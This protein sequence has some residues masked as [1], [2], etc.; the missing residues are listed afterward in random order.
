MQRLIWSGTPAPPALRGALAERGVVVARRGAGVHVIATIDATPP[1]PSTETPWIWAVAAPT[2]PPLAAAA[3]AV[4]RGAGAVVAL[5]AP[6]AAER[7]A[8]RA[9]ELAAAAQ[10]LPD[11]PGMVTASRRS[12]ET[13]RQALKVART[14]MPVLLTGETG[15][16]KEET[17]R[18]IHRFS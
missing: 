16:G 1:T 14:A 9:A 6:D 2:P 5:D 10:P 18:L 3:E 13:L 7:L 15:T 12:R 4:R 8:A 17:A 11:L